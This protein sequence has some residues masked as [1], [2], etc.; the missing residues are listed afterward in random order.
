MKPRNRREALAI[1]SM[2]R[3]ERRQAAFRSMIGDW[4]ANIAD[5]QKQI[6]A[7]R[8]RIESGFYLEP[9]EI[10]ECEKADREHDAPHYSFVVEDV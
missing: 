5:M 1:M 4:S 2:R 10:D 8:E 6:D 9:E 7:A 3:K